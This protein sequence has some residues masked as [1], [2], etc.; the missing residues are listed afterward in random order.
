MAVVRFVIIGGGPAGNSA[1]TAAARLGAEV[2]LIERD[3]VGGAAHLW[4]CVPSKAMIATGGAMAFVRRS[5][6]MGLSQSA[7]EIDLESMKLRIAGI[8]ER[9]HR[10][11]VRLL[12]DQGVRIITGKG[13]LAGPNQVLVETPG[14][15]DEELEGDAILLATG[16][17][18][19][20]PDWA[21]PDG[22]RVLTH[23]QA[24]PP[25]TLPEHLV[26][27]GSGVTGVEFVHMFASLGSQV[28]LVVSRQH[29]LPN[30]DPEV[31]QALEDDFLRR[32]VRLLKGARAEAIDLVDGGGVAVRCDDGRVARGSHALLAVGSVPNSEDLGLESAGIESEHGYVTVNQHCQ[33]NVAHIYA[34]GDLSGKLPLS[35]VAAMQGRKI[36]DHVMGGHSRSHRH[37][38][39]DKAAQAV[40]TD[41]EIAEV[42]IAEAEAFA[43]GR[44]IRVTKVPFS[45]N[46][47]ALIN[48]DWR[49]FVKIVSDPATGVVLGG[50]IV[51]RHAAE[52]ISVI[53]LAV[54]CGLRVSD[55][56][57]CLLVHPTLA[58]SLAEAAE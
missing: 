4:D 34:A 35:S 50:S 42:G 49:G 6:G 36:A 2:T 16:S 39:Y 7:A 52:L 43:S 51:G 23:R 10:S 8:E 21:N 47:K 17:R 33:S 30:K 44:K 27:I 28:T 53:A 38:D 1:A 20:V 3:V 31:A 55:V 48:D 40:F 45:S 13:R 9:L 15:P 5:V 58:E 26:V 25:P 11:V 41:P 22:D 18:P 29:V 57:D 54:N 37:L 46:A 12:V 19:R 32:G 24:Y 14:G 56:V